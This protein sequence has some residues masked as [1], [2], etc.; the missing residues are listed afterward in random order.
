MSVI[1]RLDDNCKDI[2]DIDTTLI[3]TNTSNT[4]CRD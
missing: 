2:V 1:S 4:F 3:K